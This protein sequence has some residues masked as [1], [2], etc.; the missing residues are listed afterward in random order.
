MAFGNPVT[1]RVTVRAPGG[2]PVGSVQVLV[3]GAAVATVPLEPDGTAKV[4]LAA[5]LGTGRHTVTAVYGGAPAADP[6]VTGSTSA[7]ATVTVT[8]TLPTVSTA[9]TDWTLRR[10]DPKQVH[11]QVTGVAG[12]VP[13]GTVDVWVNGARKGSA[14][15]DASGTAIVTLPTSTRTALVLVTYAGDS[16]YV[17]WIGSPHLLVVR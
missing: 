11:V 1:A 3:D 12:V 17:P 5:T 7:P 14:T 2:S 4:R 10:A 8:R 16:T 9:G 6:P 15:L 13:T